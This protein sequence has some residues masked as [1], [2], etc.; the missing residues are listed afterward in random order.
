MLKRSRD[1][2]QVYLEMTYYRLIFL[3]I[4]YIDISNMLYVDIK[5]IY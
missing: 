1:S 3:Y 2:K 5:R 4:L